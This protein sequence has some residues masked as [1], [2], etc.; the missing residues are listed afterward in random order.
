MVF[1]RWKTDSFGASALPRGKRQAGGGARSYFD[2]E[3]AEGDPIADHALDV[4]PWAPEGRATGSTA[5]VFSKEFH[6]RFREVARGEADPLRR[7]AKLAFLGQPMVQATFSRIIACD[8]VLPFGFLLVRPYMTYAM[9]SAILTVGGA[10]TGETLVGH[11]DFQLAD[12]VVQK[13]HIGN[14][15]MYL[16]SIVYQPHHVYIADNIMVRSR[17][18]C[19]PKGGGGSASPCTPTGPGGRPRKGQSP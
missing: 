1:R 8:D 18:N 13:M 10:R 4:D 12:N 6:E 16:K 2:D 7:A 11:A 9:A 19:S 5:R 15:T 14:F 17:Y 3:F